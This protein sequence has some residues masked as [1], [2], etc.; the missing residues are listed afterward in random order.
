M[1]DDFKNTMEYELL[2]LD[3]H[4]VFHEIRARFGTDAA[5]KVF[6]EVSKGFMDDARGYRKALVAVYFDRMADQ[7]QSELARQLLEANKSLP[8]GERFGHG[9]NTDNFESMLKYV[10][11]AIST[12][13]PRIKQQISMFTPPPPTRTFGT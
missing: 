13:D 12:A 7:N 1:G 11:R 10:Q 6:A 4:N 2:V 9:G 8:P 5:Q 3:A